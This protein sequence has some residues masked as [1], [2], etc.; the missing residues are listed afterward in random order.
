MINSEM[1]LFLFALKVCCIR[2]NAKVCE[3]DKVFWH[4]S[5]I[6]TDPMTNFRSLFITLFAFALISFM[7]GCSNQS[8]HATAIGHVLNLYPDGDSP[9]DMAEQLSKIDTSNCPNDFRAAYQEHINAWKNWARAIRH[10]EQFAARNND[11]NAQMED[12]LGAFLLGAVGG[13]DIVVDEIRNRNAVS[14]SLVQQAQ[15][16]RKEVERT[17]DNL[18][19][20]AVRYGV[21]H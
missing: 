2:C 17:L 20:I 19:V 7:I 3:T 18:Q 14:Q 12:F 13:T 10:L 1:A 21:K 9:D 8:Y 11:P 5:T 6:G 15:S 4:I 16:A